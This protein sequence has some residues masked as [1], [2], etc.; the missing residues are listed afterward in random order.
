[1]NKLS[2]IVKK[3]SAKWQEII[4]IDS[5]RNHLILYLLVP[6]V[7]NFVLECME[8][9]S[10]LGGFEVLFL[11][12][13]TFLVSMLIIILTFSI[14]LL[15]KKRVFWV[16]SLTAI[17]L[18]FGIANLVLLLNRV[19]PF[20]SCDL[21]LIQSLYTMMQRY[22]T[23]SQI[24]ILIG[25]I[26]VIL[27]GLV[28]L[29][30]K[31]PKRK[32][33]IHYIRSIFT[34]AIIAFITW[35]S[36][37]V[38][39]STGLLESQFHELAKSYRNN[40]FV[41][42]FTTGVID[43]GISKPTDYSKSTLDKLLEND[44]PTFNGDTTADSTPNIVFVQ[45][46]SFFDLNDLK[47]VEFSQSPIPNF[48][49]LEEACGGKLNVP[50][51]GAGTV[52]TECEVITG[53]NIDDFG[54]GEYPYKTIL[55]D[56]PSESMATNLKP[57][58]YAA[59]VIHNNTGGFYSRN[60]VYAN[61]G[62]DDFTSVEYMNG[63]EKT[64]AGWAKDGILTKYIN[65][66]LDSTEGQDLVYTISVEGHGSYFLDA[67]YDH[68]IKVLS[69]DNEATRD[70][71]E[72]YANLL[73]DMDQ[74]VADLVESLTDRDEDTILVMYG[75]HLPSL[76]FSE[77]ELNNRNIYQTDYFIWNNMGL[78]FEGGDIQSYELE[79]KILKKIGVSNGLINDYH[80]KH[81]DDPDF[82]EGLAAIEYDLLYGD[83]ILYD[84]VSPYKTNE[85]A[86][87]LDPI[88]IS[89]VLMDNSNRKYGIARG[90]NF[91]LHSRVYVN[92]SKVSTSF[93]D[94]NTLRF[95][96]DELNVGDEITVWQ[97]K[98]TSTEPYVYNT[99]QIHNQ[100]TQ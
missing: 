64:P 31:A 42:C 91:T 10:P 21:F 54:A 94:S 71:V 28:V 87:G 27:M 55:K 41:Y 7:L 66:C 3:S 56:T 63:Y 1:M 13:Y 44:S 60:L 39:T 47:N 68:K 2:P 84:G 22:F 98:L 77:D 76:N 33:S 6:F 79:S 80:Q 72:Y 48:E 69:T 50:V 78:D 5:M 83:H 65:N 85:M 45:L 29:F 12:P 37:R 40:G 58:G 35:G 90:Q 52:N 67:D 49:A 23:G 59:H 46:E 16:T 17:W 14:T 20:T 70:G 19:T 57:L 26:A 15:F 95:K 9:K 18:A 4:T 61:L 100:A 89:N 88:T 86:M 32:G 8:H 36:V 43:M 34:I 24:V 97:S 82:L 53:M 75:D 25:L 99:I 92:G 73:Y 51:V 81:A 93:I 74:F 11:R 96:T 62:F 38:G 30:F